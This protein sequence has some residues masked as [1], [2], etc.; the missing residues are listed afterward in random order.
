VVRLGRYPSV[1]MPTSG[2]SDATHAGQ[3]LAASVPIRS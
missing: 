1:Q 2:K 3:K